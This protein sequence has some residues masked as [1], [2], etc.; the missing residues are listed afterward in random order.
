MSKIDEEELKRLMVK[1]PQ[2]PNRF[3]AEHFNCSV[4]AIS[5]KKKKLK[6]KL[7]AVVQYDRNKEVKEVITSTKDK[8]TDDIEQQRRAAMTAFKEL[9]DA[10][11]RKGAM[12]WWD[13]W[14]NN[15]KLRVDISKSL[16][17][18]IDQRQVHIHQ[19]EYMDE[20]WGMLCQACRS[21][22]M[23]DYVRKPQLRDVR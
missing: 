16:T 9:W 3:F 2:E 6:E 14:H 5:K 11:D 8:L 22:L 19:D 7:K 1:Y 21:R 13:R 23:K 18:F 10:G 12:A 4:A 15:A 17:I 20:I